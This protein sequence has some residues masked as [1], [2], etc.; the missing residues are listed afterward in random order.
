MPVAVWPSLMLTNLPAYGQVYPEPMFSAFEES[1]AFQ[2]QLGLAWYDECYDSGCTRLR[3]HAGEH[4][5]EYMVD[6]PSL[7]EIA[8]GQLA[9]P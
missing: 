4:V 1:V 8:P 2:Q 9:L 5:D 7:E 3:W 6:A